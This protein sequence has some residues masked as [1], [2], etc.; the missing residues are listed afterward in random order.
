MHLEDFEVQFGP[1]SGHDADDQ[2]S[3]LPWNQHDLN[4]MQH[5]TLIDG[6]VSSNSLPASPDRSEKEVLYVKLRRVNIIHDVLNLFMDPNVLNVDLKM[7]LQNE[8]AMD[9]DGVS[10]EVYSAFWEHFLEQCEGGNER[11]PQTATRL[12]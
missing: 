9:S 12:L 3:T 10:R 1:I 8:K 4:T 6:P 7:A 2:D 11:V 5:S